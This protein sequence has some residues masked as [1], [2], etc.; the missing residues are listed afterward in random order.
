MKKKLVDFRLRKASK[1][2][3]NFRLSPIGS[4]I[5]KKKTFSYPSPFLKTQSFQ[6][7]PLLPHHISYRWRIVLKIKAVP[8]ETQRDGHQIADNNAFIFVRN[9]L[10]I[11]SILNVIQEETDRK[12]QNI[13]INNKK[14]GYIHELVLGL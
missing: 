1:N 4:R 2:C 10:K 3:F 11:K 13:N 8:T 9:A 7:F 6:F 5:A 12:I 14:H